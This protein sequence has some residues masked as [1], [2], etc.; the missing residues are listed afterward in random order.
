MGQV[1]ALD[2]KVSVRGGVWYV[3]MPPEDSV[4]V[5]AFDFAP[6]NSRYIDGDLKDAL[7]EGLRF[8]AAWAWNSGR[9]EG[10]ESD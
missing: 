10:S 6:P 9:R 2:F 7:E 4:G 5:A 8:V 3:S 1:S